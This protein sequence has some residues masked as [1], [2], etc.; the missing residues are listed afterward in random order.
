[1]KRRA[2]GVAA[3]LALLSVMGVAA[4][5]WAWNRSPAPT[6]ATLPPDSAGPEGLT[7]GPDSRIY[8]ATFGFN[9]SGEVPGPGQLL[10]FDQKSGKLEHQVAVAN[11]SS[12]LLGIA[13]HPT[14]GALLIADFGGAQV[15]D[16]D[17]DSGASSVFMTMTGN[18]GPNGLAFDRAGNLY[19]SDSNQGI[20]WKTD[21]QGG[22][23]TA[24][25]TDPLLTTTGTPPFG[26]N[27]LHFNNAGDTLFVANTGNDTV[28]KIPVNADGSP[29]KPEVFA[30]SINGAD[31]LTI[32]R[33]DNIWVVANQADEIVVLDPTGKVIA[34]LGDFNG[35]GEDGAPRGLLFPASL[36]FGG[37]FL[38]VTNLAL[39]LRVLGLPQ[40]VD[41]QWA[42]AVTQ[43]TVSRIRA[44]IPPLPDGNDEEQ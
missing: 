5:G 24:W 36:D 18:A 25:I 31:G 33:D 13:F 2:V 10:V 4:P 15:L 43:Y 9:R 44:R 22:A 29:G 21:A 32:D 6:F 14:T 3:F 28:V 38:F 39:D 30:N 37:Q 42:G 1:M 16:V 20:I 26:A 40:A 27:G 11:S 7:V 12:H 17:P 8:V 34:K 19:V 35:V 23:A 41:S